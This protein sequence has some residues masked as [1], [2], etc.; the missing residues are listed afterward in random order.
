M[1]VNCAYLDRTKK[2]LSLSSSL[3]DD[4]D[5]RV[6][7]CNSKFWVDVQN[8]GKPVV[9]I[10]VGLSGVCAS[11]CSGSSIQTIKSKLLVQASLL[12]YFIV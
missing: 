3:E 1:L 4:K 9:L 8:H 5:V 7:A 2:R 6:V 10:T 11:L 12:L